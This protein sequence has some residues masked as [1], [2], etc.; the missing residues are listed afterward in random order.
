MSASFTRE[1][2]YRLV[3]NTPMTEI[4][5]KYII[6]DVGFRKLCIRLKIPVPKAGH[7]AKIRAGQRVKLPPL[8]ENK[9]SNSPITFDERPSEQPVKAISELDLLTKKMA[10]EKLPFKVPE[11]LTKPEISIIEARESLAK[12]TDPNYPGMAV[13]GKGQLDIRVSTSNIGRALRFMDTFIKCIR[14]RGYVFEIAN[15]GT[16]VVIHNIKL[17]VN[18]RER[19]TKFRIHHKPYQDFEW[20][21]NGKVVFRIDSRLKSEWGDLK[22]KLLEEQLPRILAKL[23]LAAKQEE[24]YQEKARLW[25]QN[26]ERERKLKAE[27]EARQKKENEA[28]KELMKNAKHWKQ[29]ELIREYINA[30]PEPDSQWLAWANAKADWLDPYNTVEDNWLKEG[31]KDAF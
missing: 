17:K 15:D 7:W 29:A 16:Y 31:D 24:L 19:T 27:F 14:T 13:T 23:E 20:R 6:S 4:A 5:K 9:K 11:R 3:W 22:T 26:W 8:P 28:F 1:E 30:K 10:L 12:L 2:I 18:F 21:P 25:Q